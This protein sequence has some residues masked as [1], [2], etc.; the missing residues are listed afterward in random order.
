MKNK[1]IVKP[2]TNKGQLFPFERN[3][4][5]SILFF[6]SIFV[7]LDGSGHAG[8]QLGQ[9][10]LV[11]ASLA[12][13]TESTANFSRRRTTHCVYADTKKLLFKLFF[14]SQ[15]EIFF[16]NFYVLQKKNCI[17][18][19]RDLITAAVEDAA[20][21]WALMG[22]G[23]NRISV[24]EDRCPRNPNQPTGICRYNQDLNRRQSL[25]VPTPYPKHL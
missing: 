20:G 7:P 9:S 5:S 24:M 2:V 14:F 21:L 13:H 10:L 23:G 22:R 18:L 1:K 11:N 16:L 25:S 4:L 17:N 19:V 15:L 12:Q 6:Q 3:G 8:H